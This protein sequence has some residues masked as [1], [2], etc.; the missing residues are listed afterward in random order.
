MNQFETA[1]VYSDGAC[2][3]NPGPGGWGAIVILPG[4]F[5]VRELGGGS[6]ATTNNRMEIRGAMEGLRYAFENCAP[7]VPVV[8]FTD[9]V[10]VIRGI[11]QWIFGWRRREWKNS[12]G[13]EVANRDLWEEFWILL[14]HYGG[15]RRVKWNF[16]RGHQGIA[17]NE[18]CDEIAVA[19][20]K[21][22]WIPLYS[23][24][25]VGYPLPITDFPQPEPLPEIKNVAAEK[26]QAYSYLSLVNGQLRRHTDWPSCEAAVRGRSGA[27]FKKAMSPAEEEEIVASWGYSVEDIS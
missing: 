4:S 15:G 8:V 21:R 11:T 23:G 27:R 13:D 24:P 1:V 7:D 6:D 10:Y 25:L 18:R 12:E 22:Q 26:K 19:F 5:T 9:S 3:G 17:G 14:N 2:R 16:V 20:S